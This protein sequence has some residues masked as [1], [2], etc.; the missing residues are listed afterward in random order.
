MGSEMCIRDRL[1]S[2]MGVHGDPTAAM[3]EV[4]DPEQNH[5][6]KDHYLNVPVDLSRVIFIATANSLDTIPEPLLDRVDTVHVAGYTYDEKVAIA[7]RHLLPKQVAVHGLTPSDVA[8]SH[9]IL[10]TIAQS[11]TREAGVRTM[12]RRIGDVVR[13]KACLL[14]TSPS[15]RDLSTS[16]MPSS[17]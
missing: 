9:E 5:T 12:E 2:G 10:M 4:L 16:R 3:L 14:Y 15:P 11:Y 17:A 13:A 8:M 6:F 7:Q 1:S